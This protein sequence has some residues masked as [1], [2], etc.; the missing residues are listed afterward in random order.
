MFLLQMATK[1]MQG[2]FF[3]PKFFTYIGVVTGAQ[4]ILP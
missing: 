2:S 1:G 3:N 4:V